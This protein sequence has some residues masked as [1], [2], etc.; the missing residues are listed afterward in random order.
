MRSIILVI[1]FFCIANFTL[2]YGQKYEYQLTK[3]V[4]DS[5]STIQPFSNPVSLS[6]NLKNK[7]N[8]DIEFYKVTNEETKS[9]TLKK[10]ILVKKYGFSNIESG[11]YAFSW[12]YLN[13]T[14]NNSL[15]RLI[16]V[17]YINNAL[18]KRKVFLISTQ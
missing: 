17:I 4:S 7:G 2:L 11:S 5:I 12:N 1:M 15:N 14:D 9:D 13:I 3:L 16:Y 6:F 8:V 10:T 18:Y